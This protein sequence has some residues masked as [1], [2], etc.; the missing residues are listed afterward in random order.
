M[1][2]LLPPFRPPYPADALDPF[3]GEQAVQFHFELTQGYVERAN[4][5]IR[6]KELDAGGRARL[7][8]QVNGA[9][10]HRLWWENLAPLAPGH[11][12]RIPRTILEAFGGDGRTLKKE[13]MDAGMVI[14][15]SGWVAL[16]WDKKKGYAVVHTIRNHEYGWGRFVPLVLIDV[17]EHSYLCDYGGDR[18]AYFKEIWELLD[19]PEVVDRLGGR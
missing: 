17:W 19:W 5:L 6:L 14:Q 13:L 11:K 1:K 3:L 10:L 18:R 15:G 16:S 7:K 8:F 9:G 12:R 2:K 4:R